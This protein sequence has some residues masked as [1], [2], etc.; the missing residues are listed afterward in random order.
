MKKQKNKTQTPIVNFMPAAKCFQPPMAAKQQ[1]CEAMLKN[2]DNI[3]LLLYEPLVIS[4]SLPLS[5]S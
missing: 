1:K 3:T 4:S 5:T 2:I